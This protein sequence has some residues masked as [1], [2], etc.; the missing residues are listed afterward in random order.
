MPNY[1]RVWVPGG[2]FFFTVNLL[3]RRKHRLLVERIDDLRAA[4]R[5]AQRARPFEVIAIVVMPEHLH[6]LWQLPEGD[7]DNADRWARI[8]S[9]F[10]RRLPKTERRSDARIAKRERGIWQ[11]RFWEHMIVDEDSLRNHID[12]IHINPVKYGYVRRAVDWPFS[13][14]HRYIASSRLPMDW[15]C[16]PGLTIR[17]A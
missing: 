8:K 5:D 3:E 17:R 9:G 16:D 15:A 11:R 10:T 6:C 2:T 12:Y 4:F 1:R 7:A 14:L 13:S